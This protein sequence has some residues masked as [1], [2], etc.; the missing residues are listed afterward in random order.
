M[1]DQARIHPDGGETIR[2]ELGTISRPIADLRPEEIGL[3]FAEGHELV[4]DIERRMISDQIHIY[5]LCFRRCTHC[6]QR[7]PFKDVRTKCV[8]TVFGAYRFRGR[9]IRLCRCQ[10]DPG[11]IASFFPLGYVIPRRTTPEIGHLFAQ[12][13]ARMPYREARASCSCLASVPGERVV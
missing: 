3:T 5:T 12:L 6:G 13:G 8:L 10:V 4:R 11:C 9:R 1:D 7:Q 2:H